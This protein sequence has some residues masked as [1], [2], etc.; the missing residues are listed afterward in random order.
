[1]KIK[2]IALLSLLTI[3]VYSQEVIDKIVAVV[4]D[5]IIMKSELE[6]RAELLAAQNNLNAGVP[7]FKR[8][9]LNSL[10]EEK[11]VLAQANLDSIIVSDD[12]VNQRIEYQ[13]DMFIQQYGSREKVEQIYGMSIEKIKREMKDDVRKNLMVQ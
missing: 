8:N 7:G 12:E 9:V 13:I 10:V 6:F 2:L 4:D 11:L 1:M 5:E 3:A